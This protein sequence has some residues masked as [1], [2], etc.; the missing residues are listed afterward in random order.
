MVHGG[1]FAFCGLEEDLI[2]IRDLMQSWFEIKVRAMLG[3]D[4]K[5]DKQ[6]N[7]AYDLLNGVQ[8]HAHDSCFNAARGSYK[9]T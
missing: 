8:V 2:W 5:D 4:P 6:L 9:A 7:F 3:P 1:D